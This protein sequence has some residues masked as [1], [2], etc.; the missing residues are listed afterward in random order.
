VVEPDTITIHDL[1]LLDEGNEKHQV[2][3]LGLNDDDAIFDQADYI[4]KNLTNENSS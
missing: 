1:Y 2:K 3:M 4:F